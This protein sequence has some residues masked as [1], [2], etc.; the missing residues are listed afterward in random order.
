MNDLSMA[1]QFHDWPAFREDV[2]R[3]MEIR[4]RIPQHGD[5]LFC[6]RAL[7][8][9]QVTPDDVMQQAVGVLPMDAR[10]AW[11]QWLTRHGPHWEDDCLHGGDTIHSPTR[12]RT[13]PE[14]TPNRAPG[15]L[16]EP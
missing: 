12:R 8:T 16:A 6:H 2:K 4:Q 11:M 7:A 14:R 3:V 5:S 1:G 10:R 15:A 13:A 9:A